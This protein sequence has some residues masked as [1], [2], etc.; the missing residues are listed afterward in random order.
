MSSRILTWYSKMDRILMNLGF[1]KSKLG[2]NLYFKVEGGIL[3]Y[4]HDL[5]LIGEDELII[6][7]KRNISTEFDM[8]YVVMMHYFLGMEVW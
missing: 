7:A 2:S 6:D 5:F 1:N 4:V 3:V 8:K